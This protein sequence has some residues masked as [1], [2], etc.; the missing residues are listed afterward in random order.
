VFLSCQ[1]LSVR[2]P[3][4]AVKIPHETVSESLSPEDRTA[5]GRSST[6]GEILQTGRCAGLGLPVTLCDGFPHEKIAACQPQQADIPA[7]R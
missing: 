2:R 1:W 4:V 7:T 6:G 3:T 5:G